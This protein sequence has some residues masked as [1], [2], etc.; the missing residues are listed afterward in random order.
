M[1]TLLGIIMVIMFIFVYDSNIYAGFDDI[2][3]DVLLESTQPI[4]SEEYVFNPG[5]PI[6]KKEAYTVYY[7]GFET[8]QGVH[9]LLF[10]VFEGNRSYLVKFPS[11]DIIKIKDVQLKI[12][13]FNNVALKLKLVQEQTRRTY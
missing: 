1:K 10:T 7:S 11:P 5:D 6:I 9:I 13:A 2:L 4:G 12:I 8:I 3:K